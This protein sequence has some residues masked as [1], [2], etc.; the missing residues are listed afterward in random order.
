MVMA[1]SPRKMGP[2][3]ANAQ[4]DGVKKRMSSLLGFPSF[5]SSLPGMAV[6]MKNSMKELVRTSLHPIAPMKAESMS[7]EPESCSLSLYQHVAWLMLE[8]ALKKSVAIP[9]VMC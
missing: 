5:M 9:G 4:G 1:I 6:A 7:C 2:Q 8:K 3:M